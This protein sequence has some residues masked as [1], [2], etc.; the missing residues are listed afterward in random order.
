MVK[1]AVVFDK[2]QLFKQLQEAEIKHHVL[3]VIG[4]LD[5]TKARFAVMGTDIGLADIDPA[6]GKL[7]LAEHI[8]PVDS[9]GGGIDPAP[10][11]KRSTLA[12]IGGDFIDQ[13]Q[14][15]E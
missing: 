3:P 9:S 13:V 2:T 8:F 15:G 10:V 7:D 6:L 1:K 4:P 11:V 5:D 12:V 14:G